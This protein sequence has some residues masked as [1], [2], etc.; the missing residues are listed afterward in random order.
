MDSIRIISCHP[1]H[2]FLLCRKK[3]LNCCR[4]Q[5]NQ[6]SLFDLSDSNFSTIDTFP[7]KKT[8]EPS[9]SLNL[10]L[11]ACSFHSFQFPETWLEQF[12]F[13]KSKLTLK[14]YLPR[15]KKIPFASLIHSMNSSP[16]RTKKRKNVY[17]LVARISA[18]RQRRSLFRIFTLHIPTHLHKF[19]T[20][21]Q[22]KESFSTRKMCYGPWSNFIPFFAGF[23]CLPPLT[24]HLR[25]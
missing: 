17:L 9:E 19:P 2:L 13:S 15:R 3:K 18:I 24:S 23:V 21:K 14:K 22:V 10:I 5:N 12:P 4:V 25:N 20:H 1:I 6:R 11:A 8:G 16:R 7:W